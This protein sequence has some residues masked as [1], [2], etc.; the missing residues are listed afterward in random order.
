MDTTDAAIARTPGKSRFQTCRNRGTVLDNLVAAELGRFGD[1]EWQ[2]DI[3]VVR[4]AIAQLAAEPSAAAAATVQ[5][6]WIQWYHG[7]L[8]RLAIARVR[9]LHACLSAD[10]SDD[11]MPENGMTYGLVLGLAAA[12][13]AGTLSSDD[14]ALRHRPR[15]TDLDRA[16]IDRSLGSLKVSSEGHDDDAWNHYD[17]EIDGETVTIRMSGSRIYIE[18]ARPGRDAEDEF[19]EHPVHW[20]GDGPCLSDHRDLRYAL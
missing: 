14:P 20:P 8:T 17:V 11:I 1:D 5:I 12:G 18:W 19:M 16:E 7:Y 4:K 15:F 10:G 13:F 9:I 3:A 6:P 2:G